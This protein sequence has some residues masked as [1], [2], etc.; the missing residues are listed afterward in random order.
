MQRG[1]RRFQAIDKDVLALTVLSQTSEI[2]VLM[3]TGLM[4]GVYDLVCNL[5]EDKE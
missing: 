1:C 3:Q 4:H 2:A 5:R